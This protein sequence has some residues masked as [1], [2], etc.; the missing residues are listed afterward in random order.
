MKQLLIRVLFSW[1]IYYTKNQECNTPEVSSL[2]LYFNG[3]E[4][5]KI[6]VPGGVGCR[7]Q[8]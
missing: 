2:Y 7:T 8:V 6:P 1:K 4:K 3:L 5:A